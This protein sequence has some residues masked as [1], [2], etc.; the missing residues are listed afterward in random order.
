MTVLTLD[1]LT[2]HLNITGTAH[3]AELEDFIER[4]E[5]LITQRVGPLEPT[6]VT[7]TVDR[8]G[9]TL[10]LPVTPAISLTS[11][12][13]YAGSTIDVDGLTLDPSGVVT[14]ASG[15]SSLWEPSYTVTYVAGR[16]E[17]PADLLYA[18]IEQVRHMWKSQRGGSSRPGSAE[19]AP[20][21]RSLLAPEVEAALEPHL[22]HGFA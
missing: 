16:E 21:P 13:S 20:S 1:D 22:Q 3:D 18:V 15:G 9:A 11:I 2:A 5:A 10:V 17:C 6:D 4:A 19:N 14:I 8:S 7:R 12:D